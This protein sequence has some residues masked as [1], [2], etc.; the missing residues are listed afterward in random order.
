MNKI[1]IIGAGPAGLMAAIAAKTEMNEVVLI[2][3]NDEIG[4]KLKI[5]GGARC[6]ITSRINIDD[7]YS[8][9]VRNPKFMF[10]AFNTY[11]NEDLLDFFEKKM[12]DLKL[13]LILKY[14]Q[15]VIKLQKLFTQLKEN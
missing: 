14:T 12:Y 6:N 11:G 10:S 7:F 3:Q 1:I 15:K 2:E 5:T 9:I 8:N 4:K 13:K